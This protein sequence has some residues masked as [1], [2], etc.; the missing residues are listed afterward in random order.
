MSSMTTRIYRTLFS[1]N[2]VKHRSVDD[3]THQ[4]RKTIAF[5]G[6]WSK[7]KEREA[8]FFSM[9]TASTWLVG[10]IKLNEKE[11]ISHLDIIYTAY[12]SQIW[13]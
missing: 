12:T 5:Y 2:H 13:L 9:W 7:Y 4:P 3:L 1:A 8:C 6:K 11:Y 10:H